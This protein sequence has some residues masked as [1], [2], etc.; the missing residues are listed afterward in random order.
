MTKKR[1]L[2]AT[3]IYYPDIGGPATYAKVLVD[4][5]AP[6]YEVT[7]LAYSRTWPAMP[8]IIRQLVYFLKIMRA[9][10]RSDIIYALS[11][12]GVGTVA[13]MA[14]RW[15]QKRFFVRVAGDRAW[16]D[17]VNAGTTH[18]LIDDF[19]KLSDRGRKHRRQ[20][21]VCQQAA[22]VIVPSRYLADIVAGW[23]IAPEHI[24]LVH[25]SASIPSEVMQ[26]EE[27]R[28]SLAIPGKLIV[29]IGR[30]VSWKGFRMLIKLMPQLLELN[31]FFRLIIIGDGPDFKS[32]Q[33]MIK[34]MNLQQRIFLVG[35]KSPAEVARYL[36]AADLFVLNT[37]YE[38]FSH[39]ILEAMAAGVPVITTSVG[40]NRELIR[41]GE[42][43]FMVKYNDEFNIT[44]AVRTLSEDA[45]L[46]EQFITEGKKTVAEFTAERTVQ[47]TLR[48]LE[49][50]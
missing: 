33:A 20:T 44:E 9:A 48:V 21:W 24:R 17:A 32:L 47:E 30:L 46:R 45:E 42:N 3:G 16:E 4:A 35:K 13:A 11:T 37:G 41:Q 10:R 49:Y 19:Q 18:M 5:L 50:V 40:G 23:G 28:K 31:Q 43:G 12:L 2:I 8:K 22:A 27:A 25:N 15:Y 14:A 7:V 29:S 34:N 38:G 6:D 39:Q 36:A 26:K 1:L